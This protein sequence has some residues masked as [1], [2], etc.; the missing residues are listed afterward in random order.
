MKGYLIGWGIIAVLCGFFGYI[1]WAGYQ[2]DRQAR[3]AGPPQPECRT[4]AEGE[5]KERFILCEGATW[6]C[7][8]T[9]GG[10]GCSRK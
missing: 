9:F 10:V 6:V 7:G 8:F 3:H 1:V 5:A 4:V 2:I